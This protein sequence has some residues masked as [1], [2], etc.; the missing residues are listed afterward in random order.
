MQNKN[1]KIVYLHI[2]IQQDFSVPALETRETQQLPWPP[3]CIKD[4]GSLSTTHDITTNNQGENMDIK[5][6]KKEMLNELDPQA[7]KE[8]AP[9]IRSIKSE[10]DAKAVCSRMGLSSKDTIDYIKARS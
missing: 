7:K 3:H 2:D 9:L 4:D 5:K 6:L 1:K 10:T 8:Y